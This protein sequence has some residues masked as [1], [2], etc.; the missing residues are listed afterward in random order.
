LG[1][2]GASRDFQDPFEGSDGD[3]GVP[4][5]WRDSVLVGMLNVAAVV[6]PSLSALALLIRPPTTMAPADTAVIAF[7]GLALPA[8]RFARGMS[9]R[10]RV[11]AMIAILMGTGFYLLARAGF[12]A[13]ISVLIVATCM[14][15]V[16]YLGRGFGLG[17]IALSALA[18]LVIGVLVTRGVLVLDPK[19]VDPMQMRNWVRMAGVLSLL[20]TLLALVIDSVIRHV[21]ANAAAVRRALAQLSVAY[22]RLGQLHVR[23]EAAKEDERR[24]LAHELHDELGQSLT[25]LKLRLQLGPRLSPAA[26]IDPVAL[27]DQLIMRVRKMSVDLRPALLD[28]I[29]LVPALRAYLDNQSVLSGVAM[30]LDADDEEDGRSSVG[31]GRLPADLEIACFRVVQESVTNA[32]R[33]GGAHSMHVRVER[34]PGRIMLTIRDDGRGFDP[35]TTL[36]EAA[37]RGHLGVVGMRE[38]VRARAG[39]FELNSEPGVGTTVAVELPIAR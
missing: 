35:G 15:G 10:R 22:E 21:E 30:D 17:L 38:R 14:I 34:G 7:A 39:K 2:P 25:A 8:L 4:L 26:A 13:G 27:V 23:L 20:A 36:D 3:R 5:G 33:H 12:S 11:S 1:R 16:V 37:A 19:E 9:V 31:P 29:G 24:F 6:T 32:L 28:E 18:H